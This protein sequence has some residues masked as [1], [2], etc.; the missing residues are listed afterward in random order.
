MEYNPFLVKTTITIDGNPVSKNGELDVRLGTRM[1]NWL[2]MLFPLLDEKEC[3]DDISFKFKGTQL[4]YNDILAAK[5]DYENHGGQMSIGLEEPEIVPGG[6]QRLQKL[7]QLFDELQR[8][9]PFPDLT[10]QEIKDNF[11]KAIDTEFEASIIA[12]MS[13]GKSTLINALLGYELMPS[14]KQ[15]CTASIS[16]IRDVDD[17]EGFS[18]ICKDA[19][20]NLIEKNSSITREEMERYNS[21]S[22]IADIYIDGDIPFSSSK[23]M[24]LVLL[25]TPGPNNSQTDEHRKHTYRVIKSD[26]MPMVIYVMDSMSLR[27]DDDNTLLKVVAEAAKQQHGKQAQDRFIFVLNKMDDWDTENDGSIRDLIDELRDYLKQHD[28]DFANIYPISAELAL[29]IRANEKG[30]PLTKKQRQTLNNSVE[31]LEPEDMHF[32]QYAPLSPV[33][34]KELQAEITNSRNEGNRYKETLIHT[35]VPSV[36]IAISDYMNKYALTNKIKEAVDTFKKL[37]DEKELIANLEREWSEDDNKRQTVNA[38]WEAI[39]EAFSQGKQV[40]VFRMRI[41]SL[42]IQKNIKVKQREVN[43][44]FNMEWQ[45]LF[46]SGSS[47]ENI[48]PDEMKSILNDIKSKIPGLQLDIQTD[49]EK[50]VQ[51]SLLYTAEKILDEYRNQVNLLIQGQDSSVLGIDMDVKA[52]ILTVN[53][54]NINAL[55]NHYTQDKTENVKVG[56]T[57]VSDATWYKPW[58]W[59]DS[60]IEPIFEQRNYKIVDY[61]NVINDYLTPLRENMVGNIS[62]VVG[63]TL[64]QSENFKGKFI[65]E[66][67]HMDKL[68]QRKAKELA[69]ISQS[70]EKLAEKIK[71]DE[72]KMEWLIGFQK[73]LDAIINL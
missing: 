41:Q 1:Q 68:V 72:Y 48:S 42:D 44:K 18:A 52:Q 47:S 30:M 35:G 5:T 53:M 23:N 15:A 59:L 45:N 73:K 2:D 10:T 13:S 26:D 40:K 7:I 14:K 58:T 61:T 28:I 67:E 54:P 11:K 70:K 3:N 62:R 60:H 36:E 51:N 50:M 12:T 71:Q 69:T 63:E 38:Q 43:T 33:A 27:T 29:L 64:K 55:V 57:E 17:M 32:E 46:P 19:A 6:D 49:L 56:E 21:D 65:S 20:G 16:H 37:I 24:Q 39:S 66:L 9:C 8:D 25:D 4:D 22:N 31:T 34:R